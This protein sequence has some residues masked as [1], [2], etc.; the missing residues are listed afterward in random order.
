MKAPTVEPQAGAVPPGLTAV[1]AVFDEAPL[2]ARRVSWDPPVA[3]EYTVAGSA[4]LL[5]TGRVLP[6]ARGRN[7]MLPWYS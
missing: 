1:G 6:P 7:A 4:G 5:I 3:T 2:N